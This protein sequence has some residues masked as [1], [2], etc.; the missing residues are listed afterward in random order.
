MADI[1]KRECVTFLGRK[2]FPMLVK[3]RGSISNMIF[4]SCTYIH[5]TSLTN[6][7]IPPVDLSNLL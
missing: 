2:V 5:I 4:F 3:F 1:K 6:D 7:F